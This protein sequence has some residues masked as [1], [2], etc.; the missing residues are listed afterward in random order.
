MSVSV[1]IHVAKRVRRLPTDVL[2]KSMDDDLEYRRMM[3]LV[4]SRAVSLVATSQL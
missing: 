2:A 4:Q 3:M 1:L